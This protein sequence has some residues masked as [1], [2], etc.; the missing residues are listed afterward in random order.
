MT[1]AKLAINTSGTPTKGRIYA[2][3]GVTDNAAA[4]CDVSERWSGDFEVV[5]VDALGHGCSPRFTPEQ[6][7]DPFEALVQSAADVI[8]RI[9]ADDPAPF[10]LLMGHSMGG[11]TSADI[12]SRGLAPVDALVLED[13]A[14]LTPD[15]REHFRATAHDRIA[16]CDEVTQWMGREIDILLKD[17]PQWSPSEAGGWAQGKAQVDRNFLACGVVSGSGSREEIL[18]PISVPTLLITGDGDDVVIGPAGVAD[19]DKLGLEKVTTLLIP[20]ARHCVRRSTPEPFYAAVESFIA[21]L[22]PKD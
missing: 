10:V 21:E 7:E 12:V 14:L 15:Q 8:N 5:C 9:E 22:G 13:P 1:P 11:A 17:Y 4:L 19:I 20:T 18:A 3:H 6:L 2:L 16:R